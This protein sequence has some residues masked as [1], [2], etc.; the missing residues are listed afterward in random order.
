MKK[1]NLHRFCGLL[2]AAC[3]GTSENLTN[4]PTGGDTIMNYNN[5]RD[6]TMAPDTP[7]YRK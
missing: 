6:T 1:A 5:S 3:A 4:T 7:Y 2:L